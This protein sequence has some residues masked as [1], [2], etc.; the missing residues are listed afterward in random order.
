[1]T[2]AN[3][4]MVVDVLKGRF[5]RTDAI[6]EGHIKN[7]LA[8]GMCGDHAYASEL[9]QFYDQINLHVR[10]LIALGRDPSANELLTAE[11]LLTIFKERLSKSLQMVWEE[12][13]SSAVGEKASLDMFF[14]FLLTQVEVEESVDSAN[15]SYKA[16]KNRSPPRKLHST[17]ALITKEAQVAS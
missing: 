11:I 14:H 12:K 5:G 13:L 1:M 7:L 15:R 2:N 17:A 3:Y 6:V 9:R 16:V 8:T 10:A 4:A